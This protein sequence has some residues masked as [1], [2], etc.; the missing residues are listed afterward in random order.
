MKKITIYTDG[1]CLKNPGQ[2]GYGAILMS[3]LFTV[4]LMNG[5][6]LT[7]N[8]RMELM[9]V[10]HSLKALQFPCEV[11]LYS[12]SQYVTNSVNKQWIYGWKKNNWVR[13]RNESIPNSDLWKELLPLLDIHNVTFV[14]VRGHNNNFFNE[15]CDRIAKEAAQSL[16]LN[17]DTG[18]LQNK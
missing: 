18:Y 14:W 5:Y 15:M 3:D 6:Q 8:N 17:I 2:G 1:S 13:N 11:T 9:S 10:I 16:E 12:D 4:K 7:T